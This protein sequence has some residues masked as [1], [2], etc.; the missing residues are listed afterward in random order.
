MKQLLQL[1]IYQF[2]LY[3]R[4]Q[5][6][7]YLPN[8]PGATFRGAFGEAFCREMCRNPKE[9]CEPVCP[10]G[11]ECT[12]NYIFRTPNDGDLKWF[13]HSSPTAPRP[14]II[15][16]VANTPNDIRRDEMFSFD[17][18]LIGHAIKHFAYLVH[19]FDKAGQ[20]KGIGKNLKNDHGKSRLEKIIQLVNFQPVHTVYENGYIDLNAIVHHP[21]DMDSGYKGN[22]EIRFIF[23]T[24]TRIE[25]EKK[26]I[27]LYPKRSLTFQIL[28]ERLVHR[29]KLLYYFHY[30]RELPDLE[31][32]EIYPVSVSQKS[33]KWSDWERRSSRSHQKITTNGGFVG[34]ITFKGDWQP[35]YPILKFGEKLHI[36]EMTTFG[37]GRYVVIS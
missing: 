13:D 24:P 14:Y 37:M 25:K 2:R 5:E 9:A 1:P 7:I 31:L 4:A 27:E 20:L 12:Y 35:Y 16:P 34:S 10:L 8:Y 36:G 17:V 32:P 19:V 30:S 3:Y 21:P 28:F 29:L 33:L 23:L 18:T 15:S 6:T 11:R 22:A 26:L